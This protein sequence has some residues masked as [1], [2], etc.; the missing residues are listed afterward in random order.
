VSARTSDLAQRIAQAES[1]VVQRRHHL[2]LRWDEAQQATRAL[3]TRNRYLPVVAGGAAALLGYLL[4]RR[5]KRSAR[6]TGVLGLLVAAG[7]AWL[8]AR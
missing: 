5:S 7:L 6:G 1:Q 2:Q 4:L 3:L 8:R